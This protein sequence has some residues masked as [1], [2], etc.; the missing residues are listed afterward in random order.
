MKL[1]LLTS[2]HLRHRWF[3]RELARQHELVLVVAEAKGNQ[4]QMEGETAEDTA[5]LRDHFDRL[6]Q[7]EHAFFGD[8][9]FPGDSEL[10][11]VERGGVNEPGIAQAIRA[12]GVEGMAV[13]GPG[14]LKGDVLECCPG[15]II[16]AHQGLS[17]YRRG[18]GTNFWPFVEGRLELVGATLHWIDAGIDTGGIICHVRPKIESGDTMHEIG[19]KTVAA[20][21]QCMGKLFSL[22]DR[23]ISLPGIS[24]W[25][26]G[27]LY[28]RKDFDAQ[29]VQT[30]RRNMAEG[31][32][33]AYLENRKS[34]GSAAG[35]RI[36][37]LE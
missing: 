20:S 10:I 25:E 36:I 22:L 17:P 14:I 4:K 6:R 16:N 7:T 26:Q 31:L 1:A 33:A 21:A 32:V 23:G 27:K 30:A 37:V 18:S 34:S 15:R 35:I 3:A 2:T 24:Q 13:F 5:L 8:S 28:Q 9:G 29:A 12:H 19:C 11:E